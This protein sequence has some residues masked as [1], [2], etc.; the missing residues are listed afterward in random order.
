MLCGSCHKD[1]LELVVYSTINFPGSCLLLLGLCIS[2]GAQSVLQPHSC[3]VE[4]KMMAT[5]QV[6]SKFSPDRYN[7]LFHLACP[8]LTRSND[9]IRL[10]PRG[11]LEALV[12]KV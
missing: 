8:E 11:S 1:L 12:A 5:Q 4:F 6:Q 2:G 3:T 9:C 7:I 10:V